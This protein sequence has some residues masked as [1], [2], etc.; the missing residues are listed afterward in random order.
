MTGN[1]AT[2]EHLQALENR[3]HTHI[4]FRCGEVEKGITAVIDQR[5]DRLEDRIGKLEKSVGQLA[6]V[7]SESIQMT[8]GRLDKL[9]K[10]E[11]DRYAT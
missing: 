10:A 2:Q 6:Q 5:F 1:I 3:L 9:E 11:M 8:N 7:V 4:D